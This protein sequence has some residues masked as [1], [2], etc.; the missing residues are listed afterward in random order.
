MPVHSYMTNSADIH[1]PVMALSEADRLDRA[2]GVNTDASASSLRIAA[3]H[4]STAAT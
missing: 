2:T 1:N 4:D 3:I